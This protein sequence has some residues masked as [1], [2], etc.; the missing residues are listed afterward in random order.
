M[1]LMI[2]A[3]SRRAIGSPF[4]HWSARMDLAGFA[5]QYGAFY[6]PAFEVRVGGDALTQ[7]LAIGVSQVEADLTLGAAGRFS[8]TVVNAYD[9][10]RRAFVSGYGQAVLDLL[11]F[12]APVEIAV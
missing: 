12:G 9:N 4:R 6:V 7:T 11:R 5:E 3:T 8:F 1:T 10:K 2:R